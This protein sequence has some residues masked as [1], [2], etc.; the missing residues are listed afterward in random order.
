M[1]LKNELHTA[2]T[3]D[4]P[5]DLIDLCHRSLARIDELENEVTA[6]KAAI[7]KAMPG[8]ILLR[9]ENPTAGGFEYVIQPGNT[10]TVTVKG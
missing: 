6:M 8:A 7:Q 2:T 5:D 3:L 4:E 10:V 9:V 1:T